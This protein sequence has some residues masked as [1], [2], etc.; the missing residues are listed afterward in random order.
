MDSHDIIDNRNEKLLDHVLTIMPKCNRARFAVG[1]L[2]VSG[3]EAISGGLE[4]LEELRILIG[5][6]TN[7][8]TIEQLAEGLR[9]AEL[10]ND[11]VESQIF[12]KRT[13]QKRYVAETAANLKTSME[14]MDQTDQSEALIGILVRLIESGKLKVRVYTRGRLHAKAYIFDFGTPNPGNDGIAIVGSS[15]LSLAGIR[16]N[17]ELNVVVFDKGNPMKP[18]SGNHGALVNWFEELWNESLDFDAQLMHELKESWAEKLATPYDI[19][20]KT[21]YVLVK[22]RLEGLESNEILWD[23]EITRMLTDFQ[24]VAVRQAIQIIRDQGGCFVSDVVGT[25]KSLIGSGIIKHFERTEH[26]RALIICPK[27][28][29]EMWIAYNENFGL[30]AQ[31]LPMS[32]LQSDPERGVNLFQDVRYRD[33]DFVLI[34]ESHNFRHH[35]SQRYEELQ[36]YLATGRRVCLLT[37]TPRSTRSVDLY[38][39]IKLFHPEDRTLLPID[40]PNLKDYFKLIDQGKRRLQDLLVHVLI[41]RTRRHIL[42]WYGYAIDTDR[43]LR[44][45]SDEHCTPYLSGTKKAYVLVGGKHQFFPRRE[46]ETLRY[47][48]EE[49]YAGLYQEI[50]GYLGNPHD[51]K[52]N[53]KPEIQLTYARYGLWRYV[54]KEKQKLPAYRDLRR[55]GINLRGLIRSSL[56][57]R[58]ESSVEAFRKTLNR[59]IGTHTMFLKSIENGVIPAG[60]SAEALLGKSADFDD[61]DLLDQIREA[62]GQYDPNDFDAEKLKAHVEAD[63]QLLTRMAILVEPITP[64]QDDKLQTFLRRLEKAPIKAG[65]CLVFTQY[66]DTAKYIY[67]NLNP[68]NKYPEIDFIY[69]TG[70][71]KARIAWRFAPTANKA[72]SQDPPSDEIKLLVATDVMSE[73][74]N[75]QNCNVVLNYDLHWNPVKLIQRFGRIDRIGSQFEVIFGLNFLPETALE[76]ELGIRAV[77][78]NRIREIHETIGEDAAILDSSEQLNETAMYSIYDARQVDDLE[79]G[80]EEFMDLNEAEE[81]FRTMQHEQPEELERIKDL[82]DGVR[83]AWEE[84]SGR[85]FVCCQADRYKQLFLAD[86]SGK[87]ISRDLPYVLKTIAA[88]RTK[89]RADSLPSGYNSI[90]HKIKTLF[91]EEVKN[92]TVQREYTTKLTLAQRY[93][94]RELQALFTR[95]DDEDRKAIIN[96][97]ERAFRLTPTTA[98]AKELNALRR[99]SITGD[100][101]LRELTLIYH[102][103]RLSDRLM[104]SDNQDEV[105]QFPTIVCNEWL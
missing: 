32:M 103:H 5:N 81:Y 14:V 88:N 90:V 66:S 11:V 79:E 3:L 65:K 102:N 17:T 29:E 62:S 53:A 96:E 15:N 87:I 50:R 10:V 27:P 18:G 16:D 49:T 12:A 77:L 95:T 105:T 8:Q 98:V 44:E 93:V 35:T 68:E 97:V 69:G 25:G 101:L 36:A 100:Q 38:H 89:A 23:D 7:R 37:A 22:D 54:S 26:A 6:T 60:D 48:I 46:L 59:M 85:V 52:L 30:N 76:R 58:F 70:K 47:S 57:K 31:I 64:E 56:F 74:L 55:A 34:D 75:L 84:S 71:S 2:F 24:K 45:L 72:F 83:S 63:I 33:R 4:N 82:R 104:R 61:E 28:L 40:P 20:M 39:Q 13:E 73:G 91:A 94:I 67:E 51:A 1:Y 78:S 80:S 42:R 9:R 86:E 41:R 92:L 99:N 19:Y 21:L 43:P